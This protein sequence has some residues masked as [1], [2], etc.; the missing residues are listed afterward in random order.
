MIVSDY[1]NYPLLLTNTCDMLHRGK[2]V[3]NKGGC[4]VG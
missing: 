1:N 2:R 4:S 3:A